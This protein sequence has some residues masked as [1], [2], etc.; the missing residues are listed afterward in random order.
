MMPVEAKTPILLGA[1]RTGSIQCMSARCG[2]TD[3]NDSCSHATYPADTD[4]TGNAGFGMP[5]ISQT[6]R[7]ATP[8]TATYITGDRPEADSDSK[9]YAF[10]LRDTAEPVKAMLPRLAHP[11]GDILE[12]DSHADDRDLHRVASTN[13]DFT[14]GHLGGTVTNANYDVQ[15]N[16]FVAFGPARVGI[17]AM[18][19]SG[20]DATDRQV[21]NLAPAGTHELSPVPAANSKPVAMHR[22]IIIDPTSG[23]P[24][25]ILL[26]GTDADGDSI[27]F[28]VSEGPDHGTVSDVESITGTT[29][30]ILYTPGP[31][32]STGD[33]FKV[34]PGDGLTA[35]TPAIVTI[36]P[37]SLPRGA[38]NVPASS[39]CVDEWD[40]VEIAPGFDQNYHAGLF[41]G[42]YY[43]VPAIYVGSANLEDVTL[44]IIDV[45]NN[46]YLIAVP[47]NGV[48]MIEFQPPIII[49][50]AGLH[51][52]GVYKETQYLMERDPDTPELTDTRMFVGYFYYECIEFG[53]R[54]PEVNIILNRNVMVGQTISIGVGALDLDGDHL[55]FS[56]E[57]A[58]SPLS[59]SELVESTTEKPTTEKPATEKPTTPLFLSIG[60][61]VVT[62]LRETGIQ[63]IV[64]ISASPRSSDVGTH[65][66]RVHVSD[67]QYTNTEVF[68]IWVH[69]AESPLFPSNPA[70]PVMAGRR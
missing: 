23:D 52:A 54:P 2:Q 25:V 22:S 28:S 20:I 42:R 7:C 48:R 36:R 16:G 15:L 58:P 64:Y 6:H 51:A 4:Q 34:T 26:R 59:M 14:V 56:L 35:G 10:T 21:Q 61:P 63:Y 60:E 68:T 53:H 31:T 69:G 29:S 9:Q 70:P 19:V 17:Y 67:G 13:L 11:H 33:S 5:G 8:D 46:R 62:P 65:T 37:E 12:R 30:S 40:T 44:T 3:A 55:T 24:S 39:F 45:D 47:S 1:D 57:N 38:H 27:S 43:P 50:Q 41:S 49:R 18:T 32:F 66:I